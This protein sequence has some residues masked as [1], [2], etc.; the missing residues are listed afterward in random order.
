MKSPIGILTSARSVAQKELL[1]SFRDKQTVLYTVVLPIC[2]YPI[3]FWAIIQGFLVIQGLRERTEVR[4]GVM[5]PADA[6]P[7]LQSALDPRI[8]QASADDDLPPA[9]PVSLIPAEAHELSP[10]AAHV[11]AT[12]QKSNPDDERL[13]AVLFL[14]TPEAVQSGAQSEVFFDG[15]R[16]RSKLAKNRI[17]ERLQGQVNALRLAAAEARDVNPSQ[18]RP[19][20]VQSHDTAPGP[21][22]GALLLS[23]ILPLLLVTMAVMGAFF[24]AVDLTAGEKERGT[25]ETTLLLSLIHI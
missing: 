4:V 8:G 17:V 22:R 9:N 7:E 20:S 10:E 11:W 18:L 15:A 14:P 2:M 13:D 16:S 25:A 24:P 6:S 19:L 23:T 5:A 21:G 12:E 3:L 1:E